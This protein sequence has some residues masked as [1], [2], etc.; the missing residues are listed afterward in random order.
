[1]PKA[2]RAGKFRQAAK[3]AKKDSSAAFNTKI[4]HEKVGQDVDNDGKGGGGGD[5][6][7]GGALS[8]GQKK[9]MAKRE[10]YLKKERMVMGSLLLKKQ[11][12]Q[13]KRIDG[14]DAIKQ[15]LLSTV[16][17][18]NNKD[19]D[20]EKKKAQQQQQNFLK[21]EKSRQLLLQRESNQLQL[22]MQHP[23]FQNDPLATIR[24]HLTNKLAPQAA[25]R[26]QEQKQ[27][28]KDK[29]EAQKSVVKRPKR[30]KHRAR[31]TRSRS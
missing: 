30:K 5:G 16:D 31:P 7:D 3:A 10:Q 27:H 23:A 12:E 6:G 19:A 28:E 26:E 11:E 8:R 9:R 25:Q 14:L 1:M 4:E 13:A 17:N 2:S 18:D 29:K 24:E 15:A 22:V 20:A 21:S